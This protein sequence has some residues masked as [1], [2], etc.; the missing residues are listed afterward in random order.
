MT[1]RLLSLA[2]L[3]A[4]ALVMAVATSAQAIW[5]DAGASKTW[6]KK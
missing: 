6:Q 5:L 4:M 3:I 2:G 1:K